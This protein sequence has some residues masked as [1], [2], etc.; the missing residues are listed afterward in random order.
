MELRRLEYFAAVARHGSFTR[1]AE[2]LWI[3]QS[4]L[5]QQV[6]RLEAELGVSCARR[7]SSPRSR[8]RERTWTA[9]RA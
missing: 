6:R 4:A 7:R 9:T 1:A 5:S 3:T 8:T 2:Q